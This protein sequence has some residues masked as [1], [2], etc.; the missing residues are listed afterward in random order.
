MRLFGMYYRTE[1]MNEC[2][3]DVSGNQVIIWEQGDKIRKWR[4]EEP[5]YVGLESEI[6]IGTNDFIHVHTHQV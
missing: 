3:V 1:Q 6:S 2:C 4:K 5:H